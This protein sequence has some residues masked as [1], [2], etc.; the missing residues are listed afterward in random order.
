MKIAFFSPCPNDTF[1]FFMLW[2]TVLCLVLR[3]STSHTRTL[4]LPI[5]SRRD[6]TGRMCL[7][8]RTL[9][10]RGCFRN[11]RCFHAVERSAEAAGRWF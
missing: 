3:N 1:V 8:Y 2:C 11:M 7:K 5:I 10:C 9:R 4:I 6:R